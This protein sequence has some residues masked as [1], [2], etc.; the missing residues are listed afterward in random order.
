MPAIPSIPEIILPPE[1]IE[2]PRERRYR[3]AEA[4]LAK[5]AERCRAAEAATRDSQIKALEKATAVLA[6]YAKDAQER[7]AELRALL[8]DK[9]LQ[10]AQ[11]EEM[12]KKRWREEKRRENLESVLG[13][14]RKQLD[15]S[16]SSKD[17]SAMV[18]ERDPRPA[19]PD[20]PPNNLKV[21]L[22]KPGR[23][24]KVFDHTE[25]AAR[26][27]AG[28]SKPTTRPRMTMTQSEPIRIRARDPATFSPLG[29]TRPLVVP[30]RPIFVPLQQTIPTPRRHKFSQVP[31]TLQAI[32]ELER[33]VNPTLD[34]GS[35][36]IFA[37]VVKRSRT[38]ILALNTIPDVPTELPDYALELMGGFDS[39]ARTPPRSAESQA[40]TVPDSPSPSTPPPSLKKK[41]SKHRGLFSISEVSFRPNS[42]HY[43][44]PTKSSAS[45]DVRGSAVGPPVLA[46]IPRMS[47]SS[48]VSNESW[49]EVQRPDSAAADLDVQSRNRKK[50]DTG[51]KLVPRSPEKSKSKRFSFITRK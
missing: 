31:T 5:S 44:S 47:T 19:R 23:T 45:K 25:S 43:R 9:A 4:E 41:P 24:V 3:L 12:Q 20:P 29:I 50:S 37:P 38:E 48:V 7:A 30:G 15:A 11:R 28:V 10:K 1:P 49:T 13:A 42:M 8:A 27:Y 46:S 2:S 17:V 32:S 22:T 39:V 21:F 36:K 51:S 26:G 40:T 16:R 14:T 34:P 6:A 33:N 35:V 18:Y